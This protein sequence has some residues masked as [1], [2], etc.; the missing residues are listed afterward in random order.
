MNKCE[1]S[2]SSRICNC[3]I[4]AQNQR[5]KTEDCQIQQTIQDECVNRVHRSGDIKYKVCF[6]HN[7]FEF[8]CLHNYIFLSTGKVHGVWGWKWPGSRTASTRSQAALSSWEVTL[9]YSLRVL[10]A[11]ISIHF[12]FCM[13]FQNW[14]IQWCILNLWWFS[15]VEQDPLELLES[16]ETCIKVQSGSD[17]KLGNCNS[18]VNKVVADQLKTDGISLD[19]LK[20][21]GITNQRETTVVWHRLFL[22]LVHS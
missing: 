20:G 7:N 18:Y 22:I 12:H 15:W 4:S 2:F 9:L 3:S 11:K 14:Y 6:P 17:Q 16:V 21:L 1:L 8:F 19:R 5:W 13:P 10:E